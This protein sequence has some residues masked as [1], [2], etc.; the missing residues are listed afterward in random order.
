MSTCIHRHPSPPSLPGRGGLV[1]S[2]LGSPSPA[3]ARPPSVIPAPC[4]PGAALAPHL[5]PKNPL[6]LPPAPSQ[7][8]PS[9]APRA[10]PRSLPAGP[11]SV[12]APGPCPA[13]RAQAAALAPRPARLPSEPG[14]A[15]AAPP[16]PRYLRSG[17]WGPAGPWLGGRHRRGLLRAGTATPRAERRE[18]PG[19][20]AASSASS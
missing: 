18:R 9:R 1:P 5:Q 2:R 16:P 4:A 10:A 6:A 3:A 8:L 14:A 13:D 15:Q 11:R 19:R 7:G 12:R 17:R 20:A